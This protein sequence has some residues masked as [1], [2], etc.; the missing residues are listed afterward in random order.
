MNRYY[1]YPHKELWN[2]ERWRSKVSHMDGLAQWLGEHVPKDERLYKHRP[3]E[4][5]KSDPDY[6]PK[7]ESLDDHE[8]IEHWAE[9]GI[10]MT[11]LSQGG[12]RW[13]AMVPEKAM[14]DREH[15]KLPAL[16]VFHKEDYKDP[17]WAMRTVSYYREYNEELARTKDHMIV[18]LVAE[19]ADKDRIYLNILQEAFILYPADLDRVFIDVSE[20]LKAGVSM[21]DITGFT[22]FDKSGSEADPDK[23]VEHFGALGVPVIN[24][25]NHWGNRDSLARGLVMEYAM[26]EGIFD[27]EWYINSATG[28]KMAEGLEMEYRF[29][30]VF[31]QGFKEYWS[32]RG[33]SFEVHEYRGERYMTM[34]PLCA[35]EEPDKKLPLLLCL[36]E[37]YPGNE[38]LAVASMSYFYEAMDIAA[39]GECIILFFVL[40]D[41]DSN[42]LAVDI[43]KET[44]RQYPID[45]ERIYVTGHSH[46]GGFA[47]IFAYRHPDIVAALAT[48]GNG[49]GLTSSKETGNPVG[50]TEDDQL[51]ELSR[52]QMPVINIGGEREYAK[53]K[54]GTEAFRNFVRGWQR[55]LA[56]CRCMPKTAEEIEAAGESADIVERR[57][58]LPFTDTEVLWMDGFEH[59]IGDLVNAEGRKWTR[60]VYI[61]NSPHTVTASMLTLAWSFM[62][63][64]ARDTN[65]GDTIELY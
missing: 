16:V 15:V 12:K 9:K 51:E 30:S 44:E 55:R 1:N 23:A 38:H 19:G 58:G 29:D 5:P 7:T 45:Q 8:V 27:R 64:F 32:D 6:R 37:V 4:D 26:N 18:Y 11:V 28:K 33:L 13:V 48:L 62:R 24:V 36:Q 35:K 41:P 20:I 52:I 10:R 40:E 56:V 57:M 31:D 54:P 60:M 50:G 42:D 21:S 65:T 14:A 43:L 47:R 63:R 3:V 39:Q 17:W 59:Y 53:P 2:G 61:D 22:Y 34:T 25:G 49:P 46:D